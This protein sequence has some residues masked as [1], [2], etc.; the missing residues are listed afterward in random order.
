MPHCHTAV[1]CGTFR[2]S[3][4]PPYNCTFAPKL[5]SEP[6]HVPHGQHPEGPR[7]TP[8]PLKAFFIPSRGMSNSP[9]SKSAIVG[10]K[11]HRVLELTFLVEANSLEYGSNKFEMQ[12]NSN[13]QRNDDARHHCVLSGILL[14]SLQRF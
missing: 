7:V 8:S 10:T 11:S 12:K 4:F 3:R 1:C 6:P 14:L 2:E 9:R 13:A 5:F